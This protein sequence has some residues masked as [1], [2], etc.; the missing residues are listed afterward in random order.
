MLVVKSDRKD[1]LSDTQ[2][3]KVGGAAICIY[4]CETI[5]SVIT[6]ISTLNTFQSNLIMI[7]FSLD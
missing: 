6:T 1:T 5:F 3:S 4:V 7:H 2:I